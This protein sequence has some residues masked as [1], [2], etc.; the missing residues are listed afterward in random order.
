MKI[1]LFGGYFNP[2][3]T[4]HLSIIKYCKYELNFDEVWV[5]IGNNKFFQNVSIVPKNFEKYLPTPQDRVNMVKIV[6]K[7]LNFVQVIIS[8]LRSDLEKSIYAI[9]TVQSFQKKHPEHKFTYIIGSTELENF[10]HWKKYKKLMKIIDF[11]VAER[12]GGLENT[13]H[14]KFKFKKFK[15]NNLLLTSSMIRKGE[16]LKLQIP[17]VNDYIN[18]HHLY[19]FDRLNNHL[20]AT[21]ITHSLNTALGSVKL[22][23]AWNINEHEAFMA[24]IYHDI[25]KF[26][27]VHEQKK[28]IKDYK[29]ADYSHYLHED[30][31]TWH[32]VTGSIFAE[33]HLMIKNP[34]IQQAIRHHTLAAGEIM[35]ELDMIVYV[36]DKVSEERDYNNIQHLRDLSFS[37]LK[38]CFLEL[39]EYRKNLHHSN[40]TDKKALFMEHYNYW[41]K[42]FGSDQTHE[43]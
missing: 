6:T 19:I 40:T 11:M 32:A 42:T 5:I 13:F 20:P 24:G 10:H 31:K 7:D 22:A 33:E 25:T 35:T 8:E 3:H 26:W 43:Q 37:D 16:N 14:H 23:R 12:L 27:L 15:F 4:D 18:E 1:A 9:D 17:V 29:K 21:R 38:V 41:K 2:V 30:I 36:S 28:M 34:N 39:I